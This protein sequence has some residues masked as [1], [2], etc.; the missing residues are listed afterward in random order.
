MG[1]STAEENVQEAETDVVAEANVAE[2]AAADAL[3][4]AQP[5]QQPEQQS[6]GLNIQDLTIMMQV[7]SVCTARGA[8]RAEEME[9]VGRVYTKLQNFLKQ[10]EEAANAQGQAQPGTPQG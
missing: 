3:A 10:A 5:Q 1:K 6:E 7:I 4:D 8:I 2:Q 9:G